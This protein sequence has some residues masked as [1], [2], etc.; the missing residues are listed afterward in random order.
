MTSKKVLS[1]VGAEARVPDGGLIRRRSTS[2]ELFC[3]DVVAN[4]VLFVSS[5]S[6]ASSS[7]SLSWAEKR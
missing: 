5:M 7:A 2:G 6:M 4:R 3:G 1:D